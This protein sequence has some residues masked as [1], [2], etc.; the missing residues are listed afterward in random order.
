MIN[1]EQYKRWL[2]YHYSFFPNFKAWVESD[3]KLRG[4]SIFASWQSFGFTVGE[5]HWA[6]DKLHEDDAET[7][8]TK[9]RAE[10]IRLIGDRRKDAK[11]DKR[12]TVVGQIE[13]DEV[14]REIPH[15]AADSA[16]IMEIYEQARAEALA[17]QLT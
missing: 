4:N 11:I 16:S 14:Y 1:V 9:H 6:S 5:L 2:E 3:L 8:P 7:Y 10:I 17:R 13:A 12:A 15:T